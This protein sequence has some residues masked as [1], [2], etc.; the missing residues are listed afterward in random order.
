MS[1][2]FTKLSS[3]ALATAVVGSGFSVNASAAE[4]ESQA[5]D[6]NEFKIEVVY[7][8]QENVGVNDIGPGVGE[9]NQI[10]PY[11][12]SKPTSTWNLSKKGRYS[13]NGSSNS[14]TLYTDYLLTGKSS[15]KIYVRNN[16]HQYSLKF[17]VKRKD[18]VFDN[19][20]ESYELALGKD[21]TINLT[22][23]KSS[24]YYIEFTGPS[25]FSGYIE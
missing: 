20:V 17:K 16:D 9:P 7:E 10:V 2:I 25:T 8:T 21:T 13:F 22:L 15:V 18:L 11:G 14:S 4:L 1:K 6:S 23:D 24:N 19:T 3:L 12:T 5:L